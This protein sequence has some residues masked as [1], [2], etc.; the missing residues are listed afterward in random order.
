MHIEEV[1]ESWIEYVGVL[2]HDERPVAIE[3]DI[4]NNEGPTIMREEVRS[5][6]TSMKRGKAVGGD[7][8]AVEVLEALGDFAVDQLTSLFRKLYEFGNIVDSMC[9]K[10]CLH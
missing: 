9:G 5:A 6:M 7:G 8:I 4:G 1:K 10:R 2:Y 3:I